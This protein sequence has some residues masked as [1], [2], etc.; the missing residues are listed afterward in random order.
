MMSFLKIKNIKKLSSSF[1]LTR[2][3]P[4]HTH[5]HTHTHKTPLE[6]QTIDQL[7]PVSNYKNLN[8]KLAQWTGHGGQAVNPST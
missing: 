4:A 1:C 2:I 7:S 6:K 5:T 8:K 3:F